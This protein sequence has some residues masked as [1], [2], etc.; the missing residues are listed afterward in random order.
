MSLTPAKNFDGLFDGHAGDLADV[1]AVDPD[2]LRL[3]A[4]PGAAAGRASRVSA[5]AA[6]EDAHMQLVF[7]ALE[8]VEEAAYAE[9]LAFAVNHHP[10]LLRVELGPRN[11]ERDAAPAWRNA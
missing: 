2:L 11:I 6:E 9:E 3:D 8:I 10:A 4:K 5:I 1:L 7:L